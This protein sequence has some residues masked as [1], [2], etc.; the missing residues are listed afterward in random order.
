MKIVFAG[1]PDFA[2][3]ALDAIVR[4]APEEGW[5]VPLV[6]TQP[7]RPAGRGMKMQASPVKQLAQSRGLDVDTPLSLRKGDSAVTAQARLK[8]IA[9]DVL[10]VA[11]YGL[12]LPPEILA[13]P[14][15]V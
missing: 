10:V 3:T 4:A 5:T 8:A 12:I 9:P 13:I 6:L 14:H 11:A 2:A 7:D 15:G 1:T